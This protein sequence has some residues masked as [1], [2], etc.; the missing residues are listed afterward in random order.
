MFLIASSP[1]L[2]ILVTHSRECLSLLWNFMWQTSWESRF[3]DF[4]DQSFMSLAIFKSRK[5]R[6]KRSLCISLF[7][8]HHLNWNIILWT[9]HLNAISFYR[10]PY[11]WDTGLDQD[12]FFLQ[13][14]FSAWNKPVDVVQFIVGKCPSP[15]HHL[16]WH[17]VSSL[18][19]QNSQKLNEHE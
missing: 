9:L 3:L 19:Q 11:L 14:L 7:P 6:V 8:N 12:F 13:Q 15:N 10:I 1:Y 4:W 5:Q 17:W 2:C 16:N 18:S